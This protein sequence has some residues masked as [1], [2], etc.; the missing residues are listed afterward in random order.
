MIHSPLLAP[1]FPVQRIP[2]PMSAALLSAAQF[3]L[4]DSRL[5][6]MSDQT[7][8][9]HALATLLVESLN[10]EGLAPAD[11]DP[12]AA[13]FG[14]GLGL[15]SIDALELSLAISKQYGFQLRSDSDENRRIF[16]SLRALSAHVE[17]HRTT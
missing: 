13:L 17:Q 3:T 7:P 4:P 15:D 12:D 1:A 9:E 10:I 2:F 8:A 6:A 5:K 11:I 16:G 14:D